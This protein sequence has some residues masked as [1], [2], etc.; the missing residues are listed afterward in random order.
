MNK[1]ESSRTS[2][3]M[4]ILDS[5][6]NYKIT[7]LLVKALASLQHHRILAI[8]IIRSQ[9][10]GKSILSNYMFGTLFNIHD[11]KCT[12]G[13]YESYVK[14]NFMLIDTEGLLRC[15]MGNYRHEQQFRHLIENI[16]RNE[17]LMPRVTAKQEFELMY[18]KYK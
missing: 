12:R 5:T 9:N 3:Q 10:S 8:S 1:D 2:S 17:S 11:G 18:Q 13:I 7:I 4:P 15:D 6:Y 16:I 14:S